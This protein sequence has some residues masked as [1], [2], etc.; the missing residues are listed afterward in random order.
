MFN[1]IN[2]AAIIAYG[3][4]MIVLGY[5]I[6]KIEYIIRRATVI[7]I[8]TQSLKENEQIVCKDAIVIC[9]DNGEIAWYNV[10]RQ[11]YVYKE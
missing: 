10:N 2:Y 1:S 7:D 8:A 11:T 4:L 3:L 5:C 9:D 6:F